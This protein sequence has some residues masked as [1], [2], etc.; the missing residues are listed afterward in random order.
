MEFVLPQ[1]LVD[2]GLLKVG[3]VRPHHRLVFQAGPARLPVMADTGLIALTGFGDN[4]TPAGDEAAERCLHLRR[5]R[6]VRFLTALVGF[7]E[8]RGVAL[9][10]AAAAEAHGVHRRALYA[11]MYSR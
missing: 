5:L 4:K 11:F 1:H 8:D 2:A 9:S 10:V 7:T 3:V 6:G